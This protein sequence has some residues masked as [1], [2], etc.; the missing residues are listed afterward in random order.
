MLASDMRS[1]QLLVTLPDK[2]NHISRIDVH[3]KEAIKVGAISHLRW[4]NAIPVSPMFKHIPHNVHDLC[5]ICP[6]ATT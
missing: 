3:P 1:A 5:G 6:Y 4:A 2:A